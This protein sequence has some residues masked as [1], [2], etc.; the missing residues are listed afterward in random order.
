MTAGDHAGGQTGAEAR[1]DGG[2]RHGPEESVGH[3]PGETQ[4]LERH[5]IEVVQ[6]NEAGADPSQRHQQADHGAHGQVAP[7][8]AG[9]ERHDGGGERQ[10][11]G[12]HL[13]SRQG[14]QRHPA[15]GIQGQSREC[16]AQRRQHPLHHG[17]GD[18][19]EN[20]QHEGRAQVAGTGQHRETGGATAAEHHA[21]AEQGAARDDRD[22]GKVGGEEPV[23]VEGDPPRGRRALGAGNRPE[24]A[25]WSRRPAPAGIRSIPPPGCGA[26]RSGCAA[27]ARRRRRRAQGP[28]PPT[29]AAA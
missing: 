9:A 24:P 4:G 7:R 5:G 18:H 11:P 29:P 10:T 21:G 14:R 26:G 17:V 22:D 16:G 25:P 6:E 19:R 28:A 13:P 3:G 1:G 27:P 12:P 20:H 8:R 15:A 2:G 23:R